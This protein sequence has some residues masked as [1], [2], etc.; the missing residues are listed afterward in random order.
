M[1]FN[2]I[3]IFVKYTLRLITQSI[4][5]KK[6]I[7]P[8]VEKSCKKINYQLSKEDKKKLYKMYPLLTVCVFA[9]NF[10]LLTNRTL[11]LSERKKLSL[12]SVMMPLCD[13]L[14]DE[15]KWTKKDLLIFFETLKFNSPLYKTSLKAELIIEIHKIFITYSISE[16][17]FECL[18]NALIAQSDSILQF[19]PNLTINEIYSISKSKSGLTQ[20]LIAS[21]INEDWTE[22]H[23][24]IFYQSGI[25]VQLINDIFDIYKDL[26]DGIYTIVTKISSITELKNIYVNEI[27]KLN[28]LIRNLSLKKRKQNKINDYFAVINAFGLLGI[29]K[30]L[31]IEKKYSNK[32][33]WKNIQR[34]ELIF[35]MD[36]L[37]NKLLY[38]KYF[39]VTSKIQKK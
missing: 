36:N 25:I 28:L 31:E 27:E 24:K 16:N 14:T 22:T 26:H 18:R 13:D 3:L 10:T 33:D 23:L 7:I 30:L 35:D 29:H 21:L 2:F 32:A 1:F 38:M 17:Y 6:K 20:L 15:E 19:N 8:I 39:F 9:E 11:T 4:F 37:K 34:K 12:L 5:I